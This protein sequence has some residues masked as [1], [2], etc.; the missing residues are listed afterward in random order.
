MIKLEVKNRISMSDVLITNEAENALTTATVRYVDKKII[1]IENGVILIDGVHAGNFMVG[2]NGKP[3]IH[4]I[5]D[6]YVATLGMRVKE[7]ITEIEKEFA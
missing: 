4:N 3:T 1:S 2:D 6:A 7:A 5:D